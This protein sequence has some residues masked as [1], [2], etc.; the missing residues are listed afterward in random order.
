MIENLTTLGAVFD[1][2][3]S[4][5]R[6]RRPLDRRHRGGVEVTAANDHRIAM[7]MAVAALAVGPLDLDD[8]TCVGKSFPDFWQMWDCVI[9]S[10]GPPP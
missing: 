8:D 6:V 9:K 5:I 4:S 3:P 2:G 7:A 10:A 1:K